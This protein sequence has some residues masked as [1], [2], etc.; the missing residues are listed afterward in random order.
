M[1]EK[2]IHQLNKKGIRFSLK[3][4]KLKVSADVT[5]DDEDLKLL[6]QGPLI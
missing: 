6:R 5:P 4:D 2:I 3:N 1:I